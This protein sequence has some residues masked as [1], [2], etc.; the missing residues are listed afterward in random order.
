MDNLGN[1]CNYNGWP[2]WDSY[3]IN[4][5]NKAVGDPPQTCNSSAAADGTVGGVL[6][7]VVFYLPM[8]V[9][10]TAQSRYWTYFAVP[11]ADMKGSPEQSV[12]IR[13]QQVHAPYP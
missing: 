9:N 1:D 12:W 3:A 5:H 7:T 8:M 2:H 4:M 10:G 6:P 11:V 13:F